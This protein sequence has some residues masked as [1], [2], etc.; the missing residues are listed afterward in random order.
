MSQL[1]FICDT[2]NVS[3][4]H[5]DTFKYH[6]KFSK[7]LKH[8][9]TVAKVVT[10]TILSE[11]EIMEKQEQLINGDIERYKVAEREVK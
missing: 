4:E 9:K 10:K 2:L 11:E 7:Y 6:P 1:E 5:E 3:P 8:E